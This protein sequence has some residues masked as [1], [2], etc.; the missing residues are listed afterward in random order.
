MLRA[1]KPT[2]VN[3]KAV[4]QA[5]LRDGDLLTLGAACQIRFRQPVPVSASA[6]LEL[7]SGHR[8]RLSVDGV[9]LMAEALVLGP[10]S[11]HMCLSRSLTAPV[12]LFRQSNELGVRR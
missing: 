12:V 11:R 5:M 7:A 6:R 9:L 8:L 2:Q 4:A 10:G 3:E 1:V